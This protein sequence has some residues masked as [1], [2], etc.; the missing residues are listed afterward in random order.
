MDG[1]F[2]KE[3]IKWTALLLIF[4]VAVTIVDVAS[5]RQKLHESLIRLHVVGASD[6]EEDQAVKLRVRDA[7]TGWLQQEMSGIHQAEQART[8]LR[9]HL[10]QIEDIANQ[11]LADAGFSDTVTVSFL[12]ETFPVREYDTFSLPS[13]VYHSL[14]IRIGEAEG[15]NWWCVVFPSLCLGTTVSEMEN[16]AVSAGFDEKLTGTLTGE[17]EYELRFFLLDCLGMLENFFHLG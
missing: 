9:E 6:G 4:V 17:K 12:E 3:I 15:K 14:R 1:V 8:Y 16:T 5:D 10:S 2:M 13:G 11:T 7:V